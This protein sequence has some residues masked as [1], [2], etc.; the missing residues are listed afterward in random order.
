MFWL[1]YK[2]LQNFQFL[3]RVFYEFLKCLVFV[4]LFFFSRIDYFFKIDNDLV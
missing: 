4:F 1:F 3:D 2:N